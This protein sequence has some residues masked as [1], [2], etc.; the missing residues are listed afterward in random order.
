MPLPIDGDLEDVKRGHRGALSDGKV[1]DRHA[2]PIVEAEHGIDRKPVEQPLFDHHAA[3]PFVF[4]GGLK[5]EMDRAGKAPRL[6]QVAG[7]RQ[8]HR[9]VAVM[10]A[11]VHLSRDTST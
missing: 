9:R 1:A 5:N 6:G 3:A 8:K 7:R 10:S 4:L 11:G 2:G